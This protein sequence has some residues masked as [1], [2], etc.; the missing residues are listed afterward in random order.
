MKGRRL[1]EP[2]GLVDVDAWGRGKVSNEVSAVGL[3]GEMEKGPA[4]EVISSP[5]RRDCIHVRMVHLDELPQHCQ[6]ERHH[7]CL[8][9]GLVAMPPPQPCCLQ[10]WAAGQGVQRMACVGHGLHINSIL[11]VLRDDDLKQLG[12]KNVEDARAC[13]KGESMGAIRYLELLTDGV[14]ADAAEDLLRYR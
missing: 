14:Y 5:S 9:E 6:A 3:A 4:P 11:Q 10:R 7:G 2:K 1:F 12:R 13:G 8:E